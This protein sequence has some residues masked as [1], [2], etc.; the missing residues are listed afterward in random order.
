MFMI[1]HASPSSEHETIERK[2]REQWWDI[3]VKTS[4]YDSFTYLARVHMLALKIAC[5]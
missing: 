4:D 2:S 3:K 1:F 5:D